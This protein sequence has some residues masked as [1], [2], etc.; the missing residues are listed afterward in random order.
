MHVP[1]NIQSVV[2]Q[3]GG[4]CLQSERT[5]SDRRTGVSS[6]HASEDADVPEPSERMASE[7][8]V[9]CPVSPLLA[10]SSAL[11]SQLAARGR[12]TPHHAQQPMGGRLSILRPPPPTRSPKLQNL[13]VLEG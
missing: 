6:F 12:P 8:G 10:V 11:P 3:Q 1:N 2:G 5:Y 13:G 7:A 9:L 4:G